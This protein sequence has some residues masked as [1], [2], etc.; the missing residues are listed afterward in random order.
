MLNQEE[1]KFAQNPW[2]HVDFL[3]FNKLDKEAVLAVEVDGYA[4]HQN[5]ETQSERDTLKD[6][7][8]QQINLPVL[9]VATNES[10]EREKLIKMLEE[11]VEESGEIE[12][13]SEG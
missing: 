9:R 5:N 1:R 10:G 4:Y 13:D 7:I 6:K 12:G 11:V 3:I 2:T 8:L